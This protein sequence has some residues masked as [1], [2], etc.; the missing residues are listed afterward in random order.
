MVV[1]LNPANAD[2]QYGLGTLAL[3][4]GSRQETAAAAAALHRLGDERA[5][6]LDTLLKQAS[7]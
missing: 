1:R 5:L 6:E 4:A 7:P 3:Q 2:A